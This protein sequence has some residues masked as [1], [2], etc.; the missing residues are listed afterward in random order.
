MD[1]WTLVSVVEELNFKHG[2]RG[3]DQG[4]WT[5]GCK[6]GTM[7]LELLTPAVD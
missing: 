4:L 1:L 3:T 2:V 7:N 6:M 5:T